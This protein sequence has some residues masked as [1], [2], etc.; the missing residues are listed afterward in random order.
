MTSHSTV[1]AGCEGVRCLRSREC[2]LYEASDMLLGDH[3][4]DKSYT[5]EWLDVSTPHARRRRLKELEK[6]DPGSED[7]LI[8][9]LVG[10]HYPD[11][12]QKLKGVCLHEFVA[13]YTANGKDESGH[14]NVHE[15][16]KAHACEPTTTSLTCKRMKTEKSTT[17]LSSFCLFLS[18]TKRNLLLA[19]DSLKKHLTACYL[20]TTT[21]VHTT[22]DCRRFW[23]FR[24][25]VK[26]IDEAREA[27]VEDEQ[28]E[29]EKDDNPQVEG[30]APKQQCR[31]LLTCTTM[32]LIQSLWKSGLTC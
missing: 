27:Y 15:A 19:G 5:V 9:N 22:A 11:R 30:E 18:G 12:L 13:N 31:M 24:S 28:P 14:K 21:A 32:L 1:T 26:K 10:N 8:D 17:I 3:L 2:G 25:L 20:Q 7:V 23:H 16:S 4:C 6:L 29:Y